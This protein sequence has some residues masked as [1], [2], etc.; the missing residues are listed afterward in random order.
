M[1]KLE[2]HLEVNKK[3]FIKEKCKVIVLVGVI[4]YRNIRSE[5]SDLTG[6]MVALQKPNSKTNCK[7][8]TVSDLS[9]VKRMQ[10]KKQNI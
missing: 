3:D 7:L 9:K 4:D 6:Y 1:D 5:K 8:Q 10:N 2:N